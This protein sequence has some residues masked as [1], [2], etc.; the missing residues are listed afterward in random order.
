MKWKIMV[1]A[2]V[3]LLL[4]SL[5]ALAGV[6]TFDDLD[7]AANSYWNGANGNGGFVSGGF[8]FY[9][10]YNPDYSS[11][12]SF[13][14]S[15][16]VDTTTP[17]YAN[18][19]AAVTGG[20]HNSENYAV[21][22][23]GY[24]MPPTVLAFRAA[25]ISGMYV[26]NTTYAYLSMR[27]GDDYAKKFG[28]DTG[29]DPDW[30]KLTIKGWKD[31][32]EVGTKEFYLA[33]YRFDDNSRDYIVD[34]WTW[35]DLSSLGEVDKLTFTLSSSDNGQWGM[36]TPA[37]FALDDFNGMAPPVLAAPAA[38]LP[39]ETWPEAVDP[40]DNLVVVPPGPAALRPRLSTIAADR[41]KEA[42][43]LLYACIAGNCTPLVQE[44]VTVA[45][46]VL[47]F[48]SWQPPAIDLSAN[49][50][51]E[52]DIYFGYL[53]GDGTIRYNSYRLQVRAGN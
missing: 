40:A 6:A 39:A 36:N 16:V 3:V 44:K 45:G 46:E 5:P 19:Y 20:G 31:G 38:V 35:V 13:A 2:V 7:L 8:A 43:A 53:L 33:D 28:G 14:Y 15:N 29:N 47:D 18:Q 22:Y 32:V 23:L 50:G 51:L 25:T 24:A 27:D 52:A 21:A 1:L 41:G 37:Y 48:A 12:D 42:T 49:D 30:F 26:T 9:N 4:G 11:W 34:D 10:N 17:G